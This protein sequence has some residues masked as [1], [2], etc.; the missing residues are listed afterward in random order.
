M[1]QRVVDGL[2]LVEVEHHDGDGA[3]VPL[4]ALARFFEPR[5][6]FRAVGKSR[7]HVMPR[8]VDDL[9][10][11][12]PPLGDVFDDG[13]PA[14]AIHRLPGKEHEPPVGKF[15]DP[16]GI[17]VGSAASAAIFAWRRRFACL[18]FQDAA[19]RCDRLTIAS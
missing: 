6:E 3:A 9:G 4:Q 19:A 11:R 16:A 1:S 17:G 12:A 2:E 8:Q 14:A 18:A 15:I 5:I 7:Q 10:L 13:D